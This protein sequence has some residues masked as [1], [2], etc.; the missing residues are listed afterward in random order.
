MQ[1][2]C[3]I[4]FPAALQLSQVVQFRESWRMPRPSLDR[5]ARKRLFSLWVLCALDSGVSAD[6][7]AANLIAQR[8]LSWLRRPRLEPR[9]PRWARWAEL[10]RCIA[11]RFLA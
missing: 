1:G 10:R 11:A 9:D 8:A 3:A 2:L 6:D 7:M 4:V 5:H